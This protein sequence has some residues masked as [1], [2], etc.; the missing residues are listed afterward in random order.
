MKK[1]AYFLPALIFYLLVFL[2]SSQDLGIRF[3][4]GWLDKIPHAFEFALLAFLLA[5]GFFNSLGAS[6]QTKAA[7]T[8]LTGLLLAILD[9]FHQSFVPG[10]IASVRDIL[11]DAAGVVCGILVYLYLLKRRKRRASS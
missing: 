7:V 5:I 8:F 10:R 4:G 2:F 3:N 9:E 1:L 11:A 6:A